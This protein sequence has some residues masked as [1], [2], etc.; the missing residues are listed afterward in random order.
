MG[1]RSHYYLVLFEWVERYV[2]P[3]FN[4]IKQGA[5][6]KIMVQASVTTYV[7]IIQICNVTICFTNA[8]SFLFNL[9]PFILKLYNFYF[10]CSNKCKKKIKILIKYFVRIMRCGKYILLFHFIK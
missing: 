1:V 7:S 6:K 2:Y 10:K 9:Y 3:C 5:N 8:C 4:T